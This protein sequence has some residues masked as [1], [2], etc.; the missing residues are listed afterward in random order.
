[1]S[2]CL[3]ETRPPLSLP[4]DGPHQGLLPRRCAGLCGGPLGAH[5]EL[6]PEDPGGRGEVERGLGQPRGEGADRGGRG[7]QSSALRIQVGEG[8]GGSPVGGQINA[9]NTTSARPERCSNNPYGPPH[10]NLCA[11]FCRLLFPHPSSPASRPRP[12]AMFRMYRMYCLCFSFL[13]LNPAPP[14]PALRPHTACTACV[15][16]SS[17]CAAGPCCCSRAGGRGASGWPM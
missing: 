14:P 8:R 5:A 16:P 3:A 15:P 1:M 2:R 10:A 6:G 7:M 12:Q 13:T 17:P 4:A 11:P 9:G